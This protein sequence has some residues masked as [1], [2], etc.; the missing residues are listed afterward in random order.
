MEYIDTKILVIYP[1]RNFLQ[2][3]ISDKFKPIFNVE[4]ALTFYK[5]LN[6]ANNFI[7]VLTTR[8]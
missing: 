6:K 4:K 8:V 3:V 1:K 2:A 7:N 5:A